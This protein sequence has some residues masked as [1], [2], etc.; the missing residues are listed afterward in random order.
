MDYFFKTSLCSSYINHVSSLTE[1]YFLPFCGL[2]I[3]FFLYLCINFSALCA[4]TCHLL[5]NK[6]SDKD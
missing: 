2:S 6:Q 3:D 1:K 4:P 5:T